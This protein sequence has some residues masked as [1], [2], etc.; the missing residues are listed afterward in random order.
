VA[1]MGPVGAT[2]WSPAK[3]APTQASSQLGMPDTMNLPFREACSSSRNDAT[4]LAMAGATLMSWWVSRG[5]IA[6][7]CLVIPERSHGIAFPAAEELEEL[8]R[9]AGR[10]TVRIAGDDQHR[11]GQAADVVRPVVVG[12]EQPGELR[13]AAA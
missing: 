3:L 11:H 7:P 1:P 5:K 8:D 4:L 10:K 2:G 6:R 12:L 13:A 9:V